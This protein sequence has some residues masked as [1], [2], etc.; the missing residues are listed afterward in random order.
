M[1]FWQG[2]HRRDAVSFSVHRVK[3]CMLSICLITGDV[4]LGCLE[5]VMLGRYLLDKGTVFL[6]VI[7]KCFVGRYFE[8][9]QISKFCLNVTH[10]F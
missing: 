5:K 6:L 10:E 7:H 4:H 1:H 9:M 3:G 8:T 2:Y